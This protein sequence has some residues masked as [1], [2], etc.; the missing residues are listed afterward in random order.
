MENRGAD[1]LLP[2]REVL[3]MY[4]GF[5][6]AY[7]AREISFDE[8]YYDACIALSQSVLRGPRSEQ[9]QALIA[10]IE[11]ALGGKV[12]LQG[13]R[14]YVVRKDGVMEAHLVA[15]VCA[16]SRAWHT[17]CSMVPSRRTAFYFGMNP[18]RT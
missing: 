3:A 9:A 2:T 6:A 1:D 8:T 17:W 16:K 12:A 13:N 11:V 18:K 7:Q 5:I 10:P 15:E 14:F 4:E